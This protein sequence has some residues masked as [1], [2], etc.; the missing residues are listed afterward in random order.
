M[1]TPLSA[2]V[3]VVRIGLCLRGNMMCKAMSHVQGGRD[4]VKDKPP[5]RTRAANAKV[6]STLAAVACCN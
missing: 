1:R 4:R 3:K 6:K 5:R 2:G